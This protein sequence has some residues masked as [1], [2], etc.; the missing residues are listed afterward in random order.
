MR[1]IV[2]ME[3]RPQLDQPE[4]SQSIQSNGHLRAASRFAKSG[5]HCLFR[6][7]TDEPPPSLV[8]MLTT[9]GP[10]G[11]WSAALSTNP[12]YGCGENPRSLRLGQESP[13]R[14][15]QKIAQGKSLR[16]GSP[17]TGLRLWGGDP[18]SAAAEW[19][20][21]PHSNCAV[22]PGLAGQHPNAAGHS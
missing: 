2:L 7:A 8:L 21:T 17:Q 5:S 19:P 9:E 6:S 13:C 12:R 20:G 22:E 18:S 4:C 11:L 1:A 10:S 16:P 14:E 15:R 3:T